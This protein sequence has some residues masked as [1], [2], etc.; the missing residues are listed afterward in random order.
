MFPAL[1]PWWTYPKQQYSSPDAFL[2]NPSLSESLHIACHHTSIGTMNAKRLAPCILSQ[3]L[4]TGAR[5]AVF[6]R[7]RPLS[8][9]LTQSGMEA[10]AMPFAQVE[11]DR[12]NTSP[13]LIDS[14]V[15]LT[16]QWADQSGNR[17]LAAK[18]AD[19]EQAVSFIMKF[20]DRVMRPE[21]PSVAARMLSKVIQ[22]DRLPGFLSALDRILMVA[23]APLASVLPTV[24]IESAR[25]RM[26]QIVR[27]FVQIVD[28][29]TF[30]DSSVSRNVNLLGEAV[31]GDEEAKHRLQEAMDLLKKPG[32][33][34]VS[35]KVSGVVSQLNPWD[36]EGNLDRVLST[37]R[38][39]FQEAARSNPQVLINLDM[40]E[41]RDLDLTIAAFTNLLQEPQFQDLNAGIV[42]Q[43]YLPDAFPAL[44]NLVKWAN[45]RPGKGE[46]KIR[47]VKGANLAMEKV[48]AVIH[49]WE[50]APYD[51]KSDT[52]ANYIRC[53]DWVLTPENTSRVRIGVASHN[54]FFLAYAALL[55]KE[56]GVAHRVGFENLQ[57]MT[58][59]HTPMLSKQGHGMLLYT[60]V[61]RA[62]D[63]DVSIS[64][65]FRRFEE[66]SSIGNFL[67]SM[68]RFSPVSPAFKLEE[69]RF[70]T[71]AL[72]KSAV[73]STRRR[74]Q[75]RPAPAAEITMKGLAKSGRFDNEPDTDPVL[76]SNRTWAKSV[77][78]SSMFR[79]ITDKSEVRRI[80]EVDDVFDRSRKAMRDWKAGTGTPARR[81]L[82]NAVA[83][84]LAR[85]RGELIN[86]MVY[87]GLKTFPEADS[88]VSEAIDFATYYGMMGDRLPKDFEPYGTVCVAAPWNFPVAIAGGG[89][90]SAL[91]AGN[92]VILKP[93]PLTPR[94]AEMLAECIWR[95]GV[96]RDVL[97]FVQVPEDEVGKHLITSADGVILTGASDTASMFR[98]WKND[99]RLFAEV[100]FI[101]FMKADAARNVFCFTNISFCTSP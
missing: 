99:I 37:L 58:P 71:A 1:L 93:S 33:T 61:C 74:G 52:D 100:S 5:R 76:L 88:E 43:A 54:L 55:A 53:L 92:S 85:S 70:R 35:V 38:L 42:L 84:E 75:I 15:D 13:N 56:R 19:D 68:A 91:A 27:P 59:A 34:Y 79:P 66:T 28:K 14:A 23:A 20:T 7:L 25:I 29:V 4:P 47:L 36:F 10:T 95:A 65:L 2:H 90:L 80:D 67:R 41:Y 98:S 97:Q 39:L 9:T 64:Y 49:G 86:A 77:L 50:Q 46:I 17:G 82:F 89:V 81:S 21:N 78:S 94:C 60:P 101:T 48:D 45:N 63:F 6:A 16:R 31:L 8:K 69:Q 24:V 18:L 40:E 12:P 51:L 62:E 57:G 32:V 26:R 72:K 3:S 73:S 30:T 87:E 96:P 44:Q 83:D 11:R 22:K